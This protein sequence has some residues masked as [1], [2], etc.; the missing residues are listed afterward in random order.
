ME[1]GHPNL[2][3]TSRMS[4]SDHFGLRLL[5]ILSEHEADHQ[6]QVRGRHPVGGQ[7]CHQ[8][9][10]CLQPRAKQVSAGVKICFPF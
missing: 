9:D 5:T 10:Q 3:V 7:I 1:K 2:R 8:E 4:V 6:G